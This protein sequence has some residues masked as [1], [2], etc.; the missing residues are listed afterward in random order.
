[1]KRFR[2]ALKVYEDALEVIAKDERL[3]AE[4]KRKEEVEV[5]R[6]V[7]EINKKLNESTVSPAVLFNY[8]DLDR[9]PG[10]LIMREAERKVLVNGEELGVWPEVGSC[11]RR[12]W[13]AYVL[14]LSAREKRD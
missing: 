13:I 11:K 14:S 2:E 6:L 12:L 9:C 1:M 5:T 7:Q 10:V 3:D 4:A 8:Q